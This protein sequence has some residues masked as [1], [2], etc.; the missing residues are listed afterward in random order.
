MKTNYHTHT[1]RCGHAF[2]TERD[3]IA[4]AMEKGFQVLGFSDHTPYPFPDGYESKIRMKMEQLEEYAATI[5]RLK[6]EYHKEIEIHLGLEVEYYPSYF[7]RLQE[8][9]KKNQVE[10]F[11]LA[12]HY[13]GNEMGEFR[14]CEATGNVQVLKKY[15]SQLI[16]GMRTGYF[17][18]VAHPDLIYFVGEDIL[19]EQEMRRLCQQAKIA[20][21]PLEI[22][23]VG[24]AL[25][26]NYPDARFWKIAGEEG[27]EVIFG[28]D[29]HRPDG[30][31]EP[32]VLEQAERL[33]EKYGLHLVDKLK[34]I[35]PW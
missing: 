24:I 5:N 15:C 31:L 32:E 18:C 17:S 26:R 33:V 11:L 9:A 3:Y 1:W 22:N 27:C 29:A 20:R 25:K 4:Y 35:Q 34:L 14:C 19:Y 30:I 6:G 23:F 21:L 12:Q 10:Y 16:E 7:S 28:A 8:A 13:L 2:G